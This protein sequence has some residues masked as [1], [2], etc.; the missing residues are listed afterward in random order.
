MRHVYRILALAAAMG[1]CLA[2][3]PAGA[4]TWGLKSKAGQTEADPSYPPTHLYRFDETPGTLTDLGP[5]TVAGGEVDADGLA[6]TGAWGLYAFRLTKNPGT[7]AV[8]SSLITINPANATA[9]TI[10]SEMTGRNIRGAAFDASGTLWALDAA[11]DTLLTVNPATASVATEVGLTLGGSGF[12]LWTGTDIA[13][14]PATSTLYMT[15][16]EDIYRVTPGGA[17]TCLY[18][19]TGQQLV[20]AAFSQA[21]AA[22]DLSG[23]EVNSSDDVFAYDVDAGFSRSVLYPNIIPAF[24]AGRGDLA[25]DPVPEP[26]TMAGLMLGMGALGGYIR[27]R[28]A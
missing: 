9:T 1:L 11:N 7:G 14:R 15:N 16:V 17:M 6:C 12:N 23:F 21:A 19:D 25:A 10:G 5:V 26:V 18:T 4:T 27:R 2:V 8:D 3:P 13:Y 28:N 20:G 22:D 24:N